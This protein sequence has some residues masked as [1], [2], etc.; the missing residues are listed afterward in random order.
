[1]NKPLFI[2]IFKD[3]THYIGKNNYFDTGWLKIPNKP[4]KRIFYRLPT[5]DN[6]C[7]EG[8]EKY[9]HIVEATKDWMKV[10]KN[11]IEKL[12]NTP[13][14]EYAYIMGKKGNEIISYRITL[15]NRQSDKFK[16]GDITLRKFDINDPK[17]KGLNIKGWK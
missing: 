16:L 1:M 11:K 7:L 12:N 5:G 6:I 14:I 17:I 15:I 2:V 9:Y 4:I 10:T 3:D 8:Y 13:T